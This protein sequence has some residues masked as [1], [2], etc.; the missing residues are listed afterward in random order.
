M[1]HCEILKS[2]VVMILIDVMQ[3]AVVLESSGSIHRTTAKVTRPWTVRIRLKEDAM[4]LIHLQVCLL[5]PTKTFACFDRE[6][7]CEQVRVAHDFASRL[8]ELVHL[9]G[10]YVKH[11]FVMH[12]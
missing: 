7:H 3:I 4:R 2:V 1:T 10:W 8:R 6:W 9:I 12:R 5:A 11:N